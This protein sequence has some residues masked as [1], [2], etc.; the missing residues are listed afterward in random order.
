MLVEVNRQFDFLWWCSHVLSL[1]SVASIRQGVLSRG[2]E[3]WR[4]PPIASFFQKQF[5]ALAL[6]DGV[7]RGISCVV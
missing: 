4:L 5:W 6:A 1:L 2:Q 3:E 7:Y